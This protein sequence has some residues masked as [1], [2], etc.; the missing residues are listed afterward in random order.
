MVSAIQYSRFGQLEIAYHITTAR[1]T[2]CDRG[3][4]F[5][6][7]YC[8]RGKSIF[9]ARLVS[10]SS[11]MS[12]LG[13]KTSSPPGGDPLP[14]KSTGTQQNFTY[15]RHI[16]MH[17]DTHR[18]NKHGLLDKDRTYHTI[19]GGYFPLSQVAFKRH[20]P[21]ACTLS[22]PALPCGGDG[23]RGLVARRTID[24]LSGPRAVRKTRRQGR[25]EAGDV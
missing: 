20:T 22:L 5:Y 2:R 6:I 9:S 14:S 13:G 18:Y 11:Y 16:L 23:K 17:I 19:L 1:F 4:F 21:P 3:N 15:S 8:D 10:E 24:F 25:R 7:F 12:I